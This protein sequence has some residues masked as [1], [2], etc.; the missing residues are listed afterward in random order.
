MKIV[1][2]HLNIAHPPKTVYGDNFIAR[3]VNLLPAFFSFLRF[4]QSVAT[5]T[6]FS[7]RALRRKFISSAIVSPSCRTLLSRRFHLLLHWRAL[8]CQPIASLFLLSFC[9]L[10]WAIA[11]CV[12]DRPDRELPSKIP[13]RASQYA[14]INYVFSRLEMVKSVLSSYI[15]MYN[16][17]ASSRCR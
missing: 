1:T 12:D 15:C 7:R 4:L 10:P 2:E 14:S 8:C 11:D 3:F 6:K 17:M 16:T 5:P 13:K 9:N